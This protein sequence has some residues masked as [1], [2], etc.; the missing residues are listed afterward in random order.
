MTAFG[1]PC[2]LS[3]VSALVES[4]LPIIRLATAPALEAE[5]VSPSVEPSKGWWSPS[6]TFHMSEP[7]IKSP[8]PKYLR[9]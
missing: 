1:A 8:L 7:L 3:E 6:S 2:R 9:L 5:N 4:P